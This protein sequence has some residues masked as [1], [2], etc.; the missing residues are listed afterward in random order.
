MYFF[1]KNLDKGPIIAKNIAAGIIVPDIANTKVVGNDRPSFNP[2][3]I[4]SFKS[5]GVIDEKKTI[6]YG[7]M[8]LI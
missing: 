3:G 5:K 8:K 4:E 6:N 2:N 1:L 7:I